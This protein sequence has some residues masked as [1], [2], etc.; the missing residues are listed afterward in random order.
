MKTLFWGMVFWILMRPLYADT[1]RFKAGKVISSIAEGKESSILKGDVEVEL[2]DIRIETEELKILGAE[3]EALIGIGKVFFEDSGTKISGSGERLFYD[4][5]KKLLQ[6]RDNIY[7]EDLENEV[8]IRCNF[9][10]F[11][12][13]A[14]RIKMQVLVR[15][16]TD[17]I[18]ARSE[19]ADY[20]RGS[21]ILELTG[22]PIVYR[23]SD[24]YKASRIFVDLN[25][26]ELELD[27]GV[28]GE[29]IT[30]QN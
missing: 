10:E 23:D 28:Q 8:I 6:I 9:L 30:D 16:F 13:E 22:N 25:T 14:D 17:E 12:E 5:N 7:L 2:E 3:Q 1:I 24:V 11:D 27:N 15:I 21:Q 18:V 29:I 26:Q 4:R 20:D 19:A